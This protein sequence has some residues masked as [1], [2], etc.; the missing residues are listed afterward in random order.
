MAFSKHISTQLFDQ[1]ETG[2]IVCS[3]ERAEYINQACYR[4]FTSPPEWPSTCS[5]LFVNMMAPLGEALEAA[6]QKEHFQAT[7]EFSSA[8][9]EPSSAVKITTS[10]VEEGGV[11]HRIIMLT[12]D[13]AA[14]Q[15]RVLLQKAM[16]L[17]E[18]AGKAKTNFLA[19]MSHEIRTPL[20]SIIGFTS[21]L[22]DTEMPTGTK[23]YLNAI[24]KS[25]ESL[26]LLV[27]DMLDL[28]RLDSGT[29]PIKPRNIHLPDFISLIERETRPKTL[30]KNLSWEVHLKS[31]LPVYILTDGNMLY[32][33]INNLISNSI[34]FTLRGSVHLSVAFR[35]TTET[36]GCLEI[37][38]HDTGIGIPE[39]HHERIFDVFNQVNNGKERPFEGVGLGL[40]ITRRL[41]T[42][43]EGT[44]SISSLPGS[45]S[46]F[47]VT[48]P[49]ISI[50]TSP[51]SEPGGTGIA[52]ATEDSSHSP[53]AAVDVQ[54]VFPVEW[55]P[56][57]QKVR[58]NFIFNDVEELCRKIDGFNGTGQQPTL[59]L[60]TTHLR[61]AANDFN[62]EQADAILQKIE[63]LIQKPTI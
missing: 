13:T 39:E 45:G 7:L 16:K 40:S 14:F 5:S 25:G 10:T 56:D 55:L 1:F 48:L 52:M 44:I 26:L 23:G 15:Q 37:E 3:G 46:V 31:D 6:M 59:S 12:D 36:T 8:E 62:L 24:Y 61:T 27:N 53:T 42:L 47:T 49:D 33:I 17:A 51:E 2:I 18:S 60:I 11:T 54:P 9:K 50:L 21:L 28:S 34:K 41:V 38:V 4:W 22:L 29:V 30:E 19:T 63:Q 58:K 57:V 20:N 43:M 35:P 32:Q